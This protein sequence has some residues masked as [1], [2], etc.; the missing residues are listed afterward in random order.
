VTEI[1]AAFGALRHQRTGM[2]EQP[3]LMIHTGDGP[4]TLE[5]KDLEDLKVKLRQ[6]YPNDVVP[7]FDGSLGLD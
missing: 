4:N 1:E 2:S 6:Q 3:A 7:L 5:A